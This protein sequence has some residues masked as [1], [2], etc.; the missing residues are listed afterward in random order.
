MKLISQK[1]TET[2]FKDQIKRHQKCWNRWVDA[3]VIYRSLKKDPP[4]WFDW[5]EKELDGTHYK[6]S[7]ETF[8][9]IKEKYENYKR[10]KIG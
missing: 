8:N 2:A 10:N 4:E 6:L 7:E 5:L 3:R 9:E 1:L